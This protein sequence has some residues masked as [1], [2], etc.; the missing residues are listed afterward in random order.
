MNN[1]EF[2][3][4]RFNR[5]KQQYRFLLGIQQLMN[6][7]LMNLIWIIFA[8]GVAFMVMAEKKYIAN[9]E[10]FPM[11]T[12]I[13]SIC[14]K[15]ILIIFPIICA[16]GMIQLIG[17]CFAI[18]DEADMEIVFGDKRDVKNQPPMLMVKKKDRKSGV[19]KREF[20]TTIPMERWREK[21][22]A[23]CDRLDV[24]L[25]G[26]ITYGGRNKDKGNHIYFESAKGRNPK[27]RGVLY[28]D[29]F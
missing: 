13:F 20:Y 4:R 27:E 19:I 24:H 9:M 15:A 5:K 25:I 18:K 2:N 21:K 1:K 16:I 28:D 29:T 14:M 11:P 23:I 22:E 8:I 6:F 26:D 3:E 17:F 12:V 7:P 10:V